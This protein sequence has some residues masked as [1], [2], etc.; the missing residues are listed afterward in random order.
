MTICGRMTLDDGA[1]NATASQGRKL[2]RY[3]LQN[4]LDGRAE[5][6]KEPRQNEREVTFAKS[7]RERH[8]VRGELVHFLAKRI[9]RPFCCSSLSQ[10]SRSARLFGCKH[11]HNGSL[12]LPAFC[13]MP[14]AG[15]H[16]SVIVEISALTVLSSR[17]PRRASRLRGSCGFVPAFMAGSFFE[18]SPIKAK[19]ENIAETWMQWF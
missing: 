7:R 3:R 11:P 8:I 6:G 15:R 5:V 10:K 9:A 19:T 2:L 17:E 18:C 14:P 16:F 12:P 13:E 4:R 1:E